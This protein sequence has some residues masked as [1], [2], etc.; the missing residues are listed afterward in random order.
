M[1]LEALLAQVSLE[2]AQTTHTVNKLADALKNRLGLDIPKNEYNDK[3]VRE[4]TELASKLQLDESAKGSGEGTHSAPTAAPTFSSDQ[5]FHPDLQQTTWSTSAETMTPDPSPTNGETPPAEVHVR[6]RSP[7]KR[8]SSKKP[9]KSPRKSPNSQNGTQAPSPNGIFGTAKMNSASEPSPSPSSFTSPSNLQ[10][11]MGTSTGKKKGSARKKKHQPSPRHMTSNN[12]PFASPTPTMMSTDTMIFSPYESSPEAESTAATAGQ[13]SK[14]KTSLPDFGSSKPTF[15]SPPLRA[16]NPRVF[17]AAPAESSSETAE[18]N[19]AFTSPIYMTALKKKGRSTSTP[20]IVENPKF[21]LGVSGGADSTKA[22]ANGSKR[23]VGLRRGSKKPAPVF[24]QPVPSQSSDNN[25]GFG[26]ATLNVPGQTTTTQQQDPK[27]QENNDL[28][29]SLG[30]TT[31]SKKSATHAR[32]GS[33]KV[34]ASINNTAS[35][36]FKARQ[37]EEQ[38][39]AL[40][41]EQQQQAEIR[42]QVVLSLRQEAKD[43]YHNQD[44]IKSVTT[45]TA[46]IHTFTSDRLS[47]MDLLAV[48]LSNRAAGLIMLGAFAVAVEDCERALG[49]VAD[50]NVLMV[51]ASANPSLQ[52][53]LYTRLARAQLKQ[54]NARQASSA[55][56]QAIASANQMLRHPSTNFNQEATIALQQITTEATLAQSEVERYN[57]N[58]A[59]MNRIIQ[60]SMPSDRNR[61][62]EALI[63]VDSLLKT[64]C[65]YVY[66]QDIK[67]QILSKLDRW[68][69]VG[70]YC[71][72]LAVINTKYELAFTGDLA[73]KH[74][75]LGLPTAMHL[76][77]D[78]FDSF[79]ENDLN[80][81][82]LMLP[83]KAVAEAMLRLP[84]SLCSFYARALRLEER[85]PAAEASLKALEDKY[86]KQ[87]SSN[88]SRTQFAWL[89][90]EMDKLSRTKTARER[91]DRLFKSGEY[92]QAA[93]MYES[94]LSIDAEGIGTNG[95]GRLTAVLHC[96]RAACF[97]ALG[98]YH[99]ALGECTRALRIHDRYMKAM[100]RR[101]RCYRQLGRLAEGIAEYNRYIGLVEEAKRYMGA[102]TT[103]LSPCLFDGPH[104]VSSKD[105]EKV[106][107]ELAEIKLEK[108]RTDA[109]AR[110]QRQQWKP[111]TD[112]NSPPNND[113]QRRRD[114]FNSHKSN[115]RRWDTFGGQSPKQTRKPNNNAK[116]QNGSSRSNTKPQRK[117]PNCHYTILDVERTATEAQI[118]K[119]YRKLALK[120]H[121][122]KNSD[123]AAVEQFRKITE[124]YEVLND[125]G[126]RAKYDSSRR[127]RRY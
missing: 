93:S 120:F 43:N 119:A 5:K 35:A 89:P 124:A 99:E 30:A 74:P 92:R 85:Y 123:P 76:K 12:V 109:Q 63:L 17:G 82:Q 38:Q 68:R 66:L 107:Q 9:S 46:A 70:Q 26:H 8:S 14:E 71:E 96:N 22:K 33:Q 72:R 115:S 98:K 86:L 18:D 54:G 105:L 113:A 73:S 116:G 127:F 51:S 106:R 53:K 45:Y 111:R 37:Q 88:T 20:F 117:D 40:R 65:G 108:T 47:E 62:N 103:L 1:S 3:L 83:S 69:E 60:P 81:A 87:Y 49:I 27:A 24:T 64:A 48:L 67:V 25:Y 118:K 29:F 91:G 28:K 19:P 41:R 52:S 126:A 16:T 50:P 7:S 34:N 78:F 13:S 79:Q 39:E 84:S 59:A 104:E 112:Y 125:S 110:Q 61:L 23:N 55:L 32:R 102:A 10:F 42:K 77:S 114:Y 57:S 21:S 100:S 56:G 58:L 97:M 2:G 94:C 44:Y 4:M 6:G 11:N 101:A 31:P 90:R 121:P 95:G 80:S 15:Q 122:D 75:F 36:I